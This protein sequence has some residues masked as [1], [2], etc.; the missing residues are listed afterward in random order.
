M[1]LQVL[2]FCQSSKAFINS[3]RVQLYKVLLGNLLIFCNKEKY[4][5][6]LRFCICEKNT[7]LYRIQRNDGHCCITIITI[8][9]TVEIYV[10]LLFLLRC[11]LYARNSEQNIPCNLS[12]E[13]ARCLHKLNIT[14]QPLEMPH[15]KSLRIVFTST[16][17]TSSRTRNTF[18]QLFTCKSSH[19]QKLMPLLTSTHIHLWEYFILFLSIYP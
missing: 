8:I 10:Y 13:S 11:I 5:L 17:Y 6:I 14:V 4:K 7:T 19:F 3:Q 1:I 12:N 16:H 9:I 2:Q 15:R 18:T